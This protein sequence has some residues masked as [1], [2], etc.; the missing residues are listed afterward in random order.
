MAGRAL[1]PRFGWLKTYGGGGLLKDGIAGLILSILLV[2]QAMAYAQLA[3]L[4]PQMGLFAAMTPPLLYAVFGTRHYVSVGPVALVSLIAAEASS[5]AGGVAGGGAMSVVAIIAI[6]AGL[7]LLLVGAL[8]LG[9]L[10]NFVSEPALLGFT[11]AAAFL[12]AASQLPTLL[13]LDTERAG[14]LPA[15]LGSLWQAMP[16]TNMM[17]ALI[18]GAVLLALLVLNRFAA[19]L[20]WKLRVFPPWRQAIAKSLPLLV[21]IGAAVVAAN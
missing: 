17:T 11:A 10:V 2:P 6:Q 8:G 3:G 16:D 13:G 18:G 15:A 1:I 14:N 12:I 9:R 5:G 4:P 19:P 21:I 20:L 7:V